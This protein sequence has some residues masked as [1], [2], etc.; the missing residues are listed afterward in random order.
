MKILHLKFKNI[1]LPLIVAF[2]LNV[3]LI[4]FYIVALRGHFTYNAL[5]ASS[6]EFSTIKSFNEIS[7]N[8][9]M[10]F[11]WAYK[12]YKSQ[13]EFKNVDLNQIKHLEEKLFSIFNTTL[14]NKYHAKNHIYLNIMESFGF[15]LIEFSNENLDLLGSLKKHFDQD[16]VFERFLSS[17]N[18]TIESF[19][20]L[21]FL[22][23]NIISNG[24]YQ[25]EKLA[26]SPLQIYKNAGYKIIFVY[27]GNAS[28]YNLGRY[29]NYQG[30][31]EIIDENTLM[32]EFPQAKETKHKYGI[33][34]EFAYKKIYS[35]FEN[36]KV[37]TLVI[38]LS[39]STHRPYIHKSRKNLI[40]D[41][42]LNKKILDEFVISNPKNALEAFAYASDEFGN[43]LDQVKQSQFKEKII[44]AAT[45]DHRFRDIKMNL[46]SQKAFAYSVPFYLYLPKHLKKNVYYDKNRI[47]SHKDIF[48]TLYNLSLSN[49]KYLSLGG[50]NML[51]PIENE[52]LEFGFNE[53]VWVDKN[54][55]YEGT[56]GYFFESNSSLKDT[57]KAFEIDSYHKEFS[58]LYKELFQKQ[59][60]YR[61]INQDKTNTP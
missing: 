17:A 10:A 24:I 12:E 55:V 4:Y 33:A 53:L 13:Q 37:P 46:N 15:N 8:P 52:K 45:G 43:F 21:V 30:A 9:L 38:S 31:D 14:A 22:S 40:N 11:S 49:T 35:I 56:K 47:G 41:N 61:L 6:Y 26:L 19:N 39:I 18:N 5:R 50:R 3:L 44:I 59:L 54:G 34:D 20:R 42:G 48:P 27:S 36:A 57:N 7:T 25:K 51:A 29:F 28:W 16:F 2:V 60:N 58:N 32:Q 23:P 1:K